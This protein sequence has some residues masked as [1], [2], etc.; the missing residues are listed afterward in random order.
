MYLIS[1]YTVM[2]SDG[3]NF[4]GDVIL[5]SFYITYRDEDSSLDQKQNVRNFIMMI[6]IFY[7]KI[8]KCIITKQ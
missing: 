2:Q 6:F 1:L 8:R 4:G 5:D 3:N 7:N